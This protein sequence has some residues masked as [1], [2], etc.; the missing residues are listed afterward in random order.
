MWKNCVTI[1]ATSGLC[2]PPQ[3]EDR[4]TPDI[5]ATAIGVTADATYSSVRVPGHGKGPLWMSVIYKVITLTAVTE[6]HG[7]IHT[8]WLASNQDL[9]DR[10][11]LDHHL[12]TF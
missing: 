10:N 9:W 8:E 4:G 12:H 2:Q 7:K 1:Y 11:S 5:S 6:K 3:L